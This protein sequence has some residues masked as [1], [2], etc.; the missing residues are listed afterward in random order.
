MPPLPAVLR[1]KF[2]RDGEAIGLAF[3]NTEANRAKQLGPVP[4]DMLHGAV[5]TVNR[6]PA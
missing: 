1:C 3:P 5:I 4:F 2:I 6:G